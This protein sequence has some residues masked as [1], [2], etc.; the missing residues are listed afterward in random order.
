M[1]SSFT[2]SLKYLRYRF[3]SSNGRGHGI[4]SPFVFD[5]VRN[6]LNDKEPY[7]DYQKIESLRKEL[8]GNKGEVIVEDFGAGSISGKTRQRKI[9]SIA[10]VAAKPR[11]YGQLLY[12]MIHYFQPQCIVELG[13]SLGITTAYLSLANPQAKIYSIEG[14]PAI[15]SLAAK[16]MQALSITNLELV[17]GNFDQQLPSLLNRIPP[18]EFVFIDGNHRKV[19]TLAYFNLLLQQCSETS[20]F[21]F[22]DIHW[23]R[24]MEEAWSDIISDKRVMLS[25]D[26][27][28]I[29][30]VFLRPEFR[31]KQHFTIR[32]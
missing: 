7:A 17:T 30:I 3:S 1:Y 28:F 21:V 18:V 29:G 32:F 2:L 20:C 12:R 25:V 9:S 27:F 19:P 24:E 11:K 4:H 23:S 31:I 22:D 8:Y 26:L 6:V 13:T 15:A 10:R 5:F 14:A 16:N